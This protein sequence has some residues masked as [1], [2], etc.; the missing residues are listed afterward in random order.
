MK[1]TGYMIYLIITGFTLLQNVWL[2]KKV[3]Y[4][5]AKS[6]QHVEK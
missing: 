3:P 5:G 4:E 6:T 2:P 1:K